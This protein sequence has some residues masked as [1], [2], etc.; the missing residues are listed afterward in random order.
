[1]R[2]SFVY[3]LYKRYKEC[4]IFSTIRDVLYAAAYAVTSAY[5]WAI[6]IQ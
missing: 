2:L 6:N 5:T 1:M 4:I 3:S